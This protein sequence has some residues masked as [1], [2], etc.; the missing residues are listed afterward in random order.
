MTSAK[1]DSKDPHNKRASGFIA[2]RLGRVSGGDG[3]ESDSTG[4]TG[5]SLEVAYTHLN[6]HINYCIHLKAGGALEVAIPDYC[7]GFIAGDWFPKHAR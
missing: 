7:L 1:K 4:N 3:G 2:Q 5:G 6:L